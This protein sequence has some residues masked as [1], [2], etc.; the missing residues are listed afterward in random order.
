MIN[1]RYAKAYTEVLEIIK[2]FPKEE[3]NKIPAE[4]I[5]FYKENMDKNYI[6]LINPELELEKQNISPEANAIIVNLY[7]NY[8]ATEEQK[9]KMEKILDLN[10]KREEQEKIEK[11]NPDNIF[12]K[13][14]KIEISQE[15]NI[16]NENAMVEYKE[17][18]FVK[19]KNFILKILHLQ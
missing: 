7:F 11:Y 8:F 15:I 2:H 4:K 12:K 3:Y 17:P 13:K 5:E 1:N 6:F 9:N 19:F 14:N 18:F 10:Q 16:K